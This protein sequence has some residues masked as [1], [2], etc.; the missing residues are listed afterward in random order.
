M[1]LGGPKSPDVNDAV[2]RAVKKVYLYVFVC[3]CVCV[4]MCVCVCGH[5]CVC[6]CA[7]V[8][9]CVVCA[10]IYITKF[11]VV[12]DFIVLYCTTLLLLSPSSSSF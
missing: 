7:C 11:N 12:Q 5:V 4:R 10:S 9:V 1:S 2:D 3:V 8:H 6:V